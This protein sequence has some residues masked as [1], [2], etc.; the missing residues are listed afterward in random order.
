MP[1]PAK[2][3][4][5]KTPRTPV[6][7][8]EQYTGDEPKWDLALAEKMDEATYTINLRRSLFYYNY[9]YTVKESKKYLINWMRS[10]DYPKDKIK[11]MDAATDR[12]MPMTLCSLI[13][14]NR[15]G[16]PLRPHV[17]ERV[18]KYIERSILLVDPEAAKIV[19]PE[20][21]T[22]FTPTIQDVLA[23]KTNGLIGE[24]EYH[25]DLV[26]SGK[27]TDFK[28]YDFLT[29]NNVP[30]AQLLK[31]ERVFGDIR[32]E[33][34]EAEQGGDEQLNEAYAFLSKSDFKRINDFLN[35]LQ[36]AIEQYR[37][38]K[39]ATKKARVK[40]AP[41]KQKLVSKI[42][43]CKEH[44]DLKLVSINPVDILGATELWVYNTKTRKL[45]KFVAED[46]QT[47]S[48]KGTTILNYH[49]SKSVSKTL[50]KPED[51][52]REFN[53]AGKIQLRK[54]LE[55][56]KSTETRLKGRINEDV[57]LLKIA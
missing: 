1:I 32:Q 36:A 9:Y 57:V 21:V 43:Y 46:F 47:L 8:D 53:K 5:K 49:E 13:L 54:F 14:A 52:L 27:P 23:E 31:Y 35:K 3:K 4:V 19:A 50:R 37:G 22:V 11:I 38:V 16:M 18:K 44:K 48:V 20:A 55:D 39:K 30:Q 25:F 12:H 2:S 24:I 40:K 7:Y 26:V 6:S 42:K 10:N 34:T 28:P 51:K 56:I 45:G 15:A 41:N 17:L 29:K 33:F